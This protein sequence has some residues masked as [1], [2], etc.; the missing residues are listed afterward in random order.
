MSASSFIYSISSSFWFSFS[1]SFFSFYF[2][3][4]SSPSRSSPR[5]SFSSFVFLSYFFTVLLLFHLLFFCFATQLMPFSVI[6][7][8][9]SF[10]ETLSKYSYLFVLLL[11]LSSL[12][13]A[14][15]HKTRVYSIGSLITTCHSVSTEWQVWVSIRLLL[16]IVI[17]LISLCLVDKSF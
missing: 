14:T 13:F 9:F 16:D 4:S 2:F 1:L 12:M 11:S 17:F 6:L 7:L 8:L 10:W 5:F 3:S 15:R